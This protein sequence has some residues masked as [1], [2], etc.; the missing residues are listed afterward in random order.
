MTEDLVPNTPDTPSPEGTEEGQKAPEQGTSAQTTEH[1][2]QID[3]KY[4]GKSA[5]DLAKM[6][7]EKEAFIGKQATEIGQVRTLA[8]QVN[9][10]RGLLESR[11]EQ[12]REPVAEKEDEFD[13]TRPNEFVSK[14]VKKEID[15]LRREL[16]Q[17]EAVKYVQSARYNMERGKTA[18]VAQNRELFAGIEQDVEAELAKQIRGGTLSPELLGEPKTW[19]AAATIMRIMRDE[20]DK[21]V[22]PKRSGMAAPN[23]GFQAT[24]RKGTTDDDDVQLD[25]AD[26]EWMRTYGYDE[27]TLLDGVRK[28]RKMAIEGNLR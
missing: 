26:R 18:A 25:D 10:L 8:E 11:Q 4:A 24:A 16:A 2:E 1:T 21:I 6:L 22:S 28:G 15:G 7:D 17:R 27:K 19:K 23:S 9:Y 13:F 5:A 20:E 3:A 14:A 12:Q